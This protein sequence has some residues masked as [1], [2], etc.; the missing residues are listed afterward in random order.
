M[1]LSVEVDP[2]EVGFDA[3]RLDRIGDHLHR[4]VDDGRLPGTQVLVTRGGQVVYVDR[5]GMADMERGVAVAEDTV[6]RIYSM[7][8]PIT[9]IA[10]MQLY[11]QGRFQLKDPISKWIP[12][13]SDARVFASGNADQY[14]T[15]E[16]GREIS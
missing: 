2:A 6:Y 3:D 1:T 11:E 16:P 4:Y 13:F 9:S 12:S 10:A 5:Y 8:K 15:R 14:Q 7:S